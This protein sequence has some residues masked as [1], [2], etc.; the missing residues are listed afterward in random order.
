[1]NGEPSLYQYCVSVSFVWQDA[2]FVIF[3]LLQ[4]MQNMDHCMHTWKTRPLLYTLHKFYSGLVTLLLVS[5]LLILNWSSQRVATLRE[6][7]VDILVST[8]SL[9]KNSAKCFSVFQTRTHACLAR[10]YQSVT[11]ISVNLVTDLAY[12]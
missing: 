6:I 11:S 10:L 5:L 2:T 1:M 4:N 9:Q 8:F 12:I 7:T 3:S